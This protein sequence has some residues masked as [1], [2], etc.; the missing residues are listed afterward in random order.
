MRYQRPAPAR[1][2]VRG[3]RGREEGDESERER[4]EREKEKPSHCHYG[5]ILVLIFN[6]CECCV[7]DTNIGM[8]LY[9]T[10][11]TYIYFSNRPFTIM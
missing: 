10:C 8:Q 1:L 11:Y 6:N 9:V 4:Q 3:G 7:E 5:C 2:E